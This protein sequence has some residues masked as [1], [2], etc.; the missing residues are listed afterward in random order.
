MTGQALVMHECSESQHAAPRFLRYDRIVP[1]QPRQQHAVAVPSPRSPLRRR[2][3]AMITCTSLVRCA[4]RRKRRT[5]TH[6]DTDN[7]FV[8]V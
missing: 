5:K 7:F 2:K 1:R 6:K 4:Y 3:E 8:T